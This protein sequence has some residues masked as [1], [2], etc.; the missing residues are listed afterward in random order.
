MKKKL[1]SIL[2]CAMIGIMTIGC[3]S[4]DKDDA[5]GSDSKTEG[6]ADAQDGKEAVDKN[7]SLQ[8]SDSYTFTDP[9][10]IEFD[11]R[12]V[13][14]GDEN[15]KLISNMANMGYT[16]SKMYD[17]IYLNDGSPAAEYQYFVTADEASATA[18]AQF[19]TSQGQKITQEGN[20]LYAFVDGD[21][22]EGSIISL[23]GTG[24]I[25]DET[26]EAY[27][28]MMKSFNGLVDYE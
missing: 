19:Y 2:M 16:A 24:A 13:L 12:Y 8:M 1:I 17:I 4:S 14:E 15:S 11:Q 22:L 10:D 7:F 26:V 28:E 18:L 3:G 20:V 27:V 5:K 25:S 6:K 21:T 23:A 9:Q